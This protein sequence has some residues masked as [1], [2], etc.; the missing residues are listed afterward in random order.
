MR[1]LLDIVAVGLLCSSLY[2]AS[3]A[4]FVLEFAA[5]D[6]TKLLGVGWI[7]CSVISA[8]FGTLIIGVC[9]PPSKGGLQ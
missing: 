7:L 2:F 6:I 8:G 4:F 9:Y 3:Q 1:V 5:E